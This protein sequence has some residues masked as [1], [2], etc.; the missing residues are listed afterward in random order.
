MIHIY[1]SEQDLEHIANNKIFASCQLSSC[2]IGEE[3]KKLFL[4]TIASE[5]DRD[6][7]PVSTILVS[8][9][10]NKND[11]VFS[12]ED[13]VAAQCTP[14]HKPLNKQH[15]P[16]DIVGHITKSVLVDNEL[17]IIDEEP[18]TDCHILAEGVIY[19]HLGSMEDGLQDEIAEF[20]DELQSG[21]WF[22]SME[23]LF[24]GFDYA[25]THPTL[26]NAVIVRNENTA[27]LTRHLR[28]YGGTGTYGDFQIGRLLRNLT[29]SAEGFV[30]NPANPKS[31]V[32]NNREFAAIAK[33]LDELQ[34]TDVSIG[35]SN[36]ADDFEVKYAEALTEIKDLRDKLAEA[37]VQA[38]AKT[39]E[40]NKTVIAELEEQIVAK[41]EKIAELETAVAENDKSLKDAVA[42]VAELQASLDEAKEQLKTI[43]ADKMKTDR[44]SLMIDAGIEKSDAE[45]TVE[46]FANVSDEQF[47]KIV[48]L[49]KPA[50]V[51]E[52]VDEEV[53]EDKDGESAVEASEIETDEV[54]ETVLAAEQTEENS[55]VKQLES[56]L[57][58]KLVVNK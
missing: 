21:E 57:T 23:T 19:R 6:L 51:A 33:T 38:Y 48:D 14:T 46:E 42:A 44:V 53:D 22:V 52:A 4:K 8:T 31:L 11:D 56:F 39:I 24:G 5:Y 16:R 36:M 7:Y 20:I 13:L 28:S 43:A 9:G 10:W 50:V 37:D 15:K 26:G 32:L 35:E 17:N 29:F 54:D 34:I 41:D 18:S 45:A 25:V 3:D 27:F 40:D 30:K 49:K 1:K 58:N 55:V 2:E 12:V 47:L